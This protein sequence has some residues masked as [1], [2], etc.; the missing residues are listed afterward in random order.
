MTSAS[1]SWSQIRF[2]IQFPHF[3][4][5]CKQPSQSVFFTFCPPRERIFSIHLAKARPN[6]RVAP[7][8][9]QL[10]EFVC[11]FCEWQQGI[12]NVPPSGH[13]HTKWHTLFLAS[14]PPFRLQ[15]LLSTDLPLFRQLAKKALIV[16][17]WK[18]FC[19]VEGT[20]PESGV[21]KTNF[22]PAKKR[23]LSRRFLPSFFF[24]DEGRKSKVRCLSQS[25]NRR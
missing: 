23:H 16:W 2:L 12:K 14:S 18:N 7:A 1:A 25:S 8:S 11:A 17:S 24:E 19:W 4:I 3:Y 5:L 15:L 6:F 22:S 13:S 9:Q 20:L 10:I 21:G